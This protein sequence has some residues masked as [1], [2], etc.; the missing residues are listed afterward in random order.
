MSTADDT[1]RALQSSSLQRMAGYNQ[2][3]TK[4]SSSL[5]QTSEL[6]KQDY[7]RVNL[8]SGQTYINTEMLV[9]CRKYALNN[10]HCNRQQDKSNVGRLKHVKQNCGHEL[11]KSTVS[12]RGRLAV[13]SMWSCRVLWKVERQGFSQIVSKLIWIYV[14]LWW[15]LFCL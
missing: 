6:R 12:D 13:A 2:W 4:G 14:F 9:K 10:Q 15:W 5:L 11:R 1:Q 8:S 3:F 7:S